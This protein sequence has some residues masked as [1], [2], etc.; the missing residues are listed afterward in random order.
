MELDQP[1]NK[2]DKIRINIKRSMAGKKTYEYT[3]RADNIDELVILLNEVE[4]EC[5]KTIKESEPNE[6]H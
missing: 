6:Q 2:E 3:V 5:E 4:R 1:T